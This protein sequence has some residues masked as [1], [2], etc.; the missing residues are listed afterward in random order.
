MSPCP[1]TSPIN[2]E[3]RKAFRARL[4]N[5]VGLQRRWIMCCRSCSLGRV[6]EFATEM[7]IHLSGMENLEMPGVMVF[8]KVLVCLDCGFSEFTV[9][10]SDLASLAGCTKINAV[11]IR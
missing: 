4:L 1:Q 5:P 9:P 3:F 6:A 2:D 11:A 10:E 8:P 7:V